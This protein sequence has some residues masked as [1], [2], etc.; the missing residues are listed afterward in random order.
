MCELMQDANRATTL[1]SSG[2]DG[3]AELLFADGLRAREG[4]E[5]ATWSDL[6]EGE[7][8]ETCVAT[9]GVA[10]GIAMLSK[11]WWVENDEVVFVLDVVE[12]F[13]SIDSIGFVARV[14]RE[15]EFDVFVGEFDCFGRTVD[16]VNEIG[17]TAH[18]IERET[19]CVAEHI[20]Y[21]ATFCV[22]F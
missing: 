14:A 16:R 3:K 18:S 20:E 8:I 1:C 17:T 15:V 9:E 10:D 6:L 11:C 2:E 19:T 5:D 22:V 13:E 12:E 7:G 4:E 21:V